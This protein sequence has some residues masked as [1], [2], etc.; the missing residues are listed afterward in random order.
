MKKKRLVIF[1]GFL[2]LS[3]IAIFV[4]M[5]GEQTQIEESELEA[6]QIPY[7]IQGPHTVGYRPN[8]SPDS[9]P[10][11]VH[12]WYPASNSDQMEKDIQYRYSM[13]FGKPLGNTTIATYSGMAIPEGN[14]DDLRG[15]YPLVILSPGF[16]IGSTAYA[17]LAEHIA[18]YGFVVI[19]P[20]HIE[21]LDP[22]DQLWRSAI[23]RP[24][25]IV[26]LLA[27]VDGIIDE[28]GFL[29]G[30]AAPNQIAIV[31][32]S[33][34]GY[35][36]LSAGGAKIHSRSFESHCREAI[37]TEEPGAWLCEMLVTHIRDMAEAAGFDSNEDAYRAAEIDPRIS[38]IV[39][40]AG[41]A[42]FFGPEGLAEIEI[43]VLAIGGTDDVDSPYL[44]GTYPTFEYANSGYKAL[45]GLRGAEHMIFTGPCENVRWFIRPLTGEFC[46][47]GDWNRAT[48]HSLTK[49]FVTAFLLCELKNDEEARIYL[50]PMNA[51]IQEIDFASMGY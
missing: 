15:P 18:S 37:E 1:A 33:Y 29:N 6:E 35:T 41:D 46:S 28:G 7:S 45:V 47:D 27:V 39:P 10:L 12:I 14:K 40:I 11:K 19:S 31:G 24:N 2:V 49:H 36:A 9:F 30:L 22:E 42:F 4:F 43:P 32:H 48:A 5:G 3:G 8:I 44:W 21:H 25:D 34:G 20:E 17:W 26:E 50:N 51:E 38:A 16:S 13:K 23:E